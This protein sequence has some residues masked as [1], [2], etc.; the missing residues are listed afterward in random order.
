[1]APSA[2]S[3]DTITM[4]VLEHIAFFLGTVTFLGPPS[5]IVALLST[6]RRIHSC[7]STASNHH[8]YARIFAYK[9]D[10][11]SASRR[12]NPEC[13]TAAALSG[14][15]QRRFFYLGRVRE[16]L[17]SVVKPSQVRSGGEALQQVLW[18]AYLMML[19]NDGKNEQQLRDYA[20]MDLWLNEYFFH[21]HGASYAKSSIGVN[22]WPEHNE[23][24]ALA[25]WTFWFLLKPG[26][27]YLP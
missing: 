4:D 3:L 16:R 8:L 18:V 1:M 27:L 5:A 22:R 20:R 26:E 15:L 25:M 7:L 17:D 6:N 10:C 12:L 23:Q 13:T 11:A 19:E 2:L 21:D 14:E 9:F 24:T